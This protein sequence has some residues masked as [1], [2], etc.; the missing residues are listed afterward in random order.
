MR[1]SI[2]AILGTGEI[3]IGIMILTRPIAPLVWTAGEP[4]RAVRQR[5]VRDVTA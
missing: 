5:S 1:E 2:A 4:L 3:I